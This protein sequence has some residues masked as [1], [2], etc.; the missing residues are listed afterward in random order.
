M[1]RQAERMPILHSTFIQTPTLVEVQVMS[2]R[3]SSARRGMRTMP[4]M[5]TLRSGLERP[6]ENR[7]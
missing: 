4:A 2:E 1:G 6:G 5:Q 7:R 3:S